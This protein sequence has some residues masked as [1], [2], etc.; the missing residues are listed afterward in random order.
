MDFKEINA[1]NYFSEY[2]KKIKIFIFEIVY[3]LQIK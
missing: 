1:L 2:F 3:I